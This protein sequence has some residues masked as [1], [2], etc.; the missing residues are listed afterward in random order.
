[1]ISN[2]YGLQ[3]VDTTVCCAGLLLRARAREHLKSVFFIT[4]PVEIIIFRVHVLYAVFMTSTGAENWKRGRSRWLPPVLS[5]P[6]TTI[7]GYGSSST[8]VAP[9]GPGPSIING[10]RAFPHEFPCY[11]EGQGCGGSLIWRDIVLTSAHCGLYFENDAI[12]GAYRYQSTQYG[13]ER[14]KVAKSIA[15]PRWNPKLNLFDFRILKLEFPVRKSCTLR[16]SSKL[17]ESTTTHAIPRL[18]LRSMR[19]GWA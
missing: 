18:V 15:H 16:G 11:V 5:A 14:I 3:K 12:V 10:N 17:A 2:Y 7:A 6:T 4:V 19:L 8:A 1:M 13:A 9:T